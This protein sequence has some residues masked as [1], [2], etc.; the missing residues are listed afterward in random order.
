MLINIVNGLISIIYLIVGAIL[1]L[2][3]DTPFDFGQLS[4]GSFG[5]LIG[6]IFPV[7]SMFDHM[8]V[9]LTAFLLYYV[10]RWLLR[11]IRQIQ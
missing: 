11:I 5:D 4:W 1:G 10:I 6:L 2:L 3:P 7:Q 8:T 9:I